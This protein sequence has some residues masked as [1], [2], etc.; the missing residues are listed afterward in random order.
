MKSK[1]FT[2]VFFMIIFSGFGASATIEMNKGWN[3]ISSHANGLGVSEIE[4]ECDREGGP[5][6]W[7][8]EQGEF[9]YLN[10]GE[11]QDMNPYKGYWVKVESDCE[12][13]FKGTPPEKDKLD[14]H[15]GWNLVSSAFENWGREEIDDYCARS[16]G[17]WYD[18]NSGWE[19][20]LENNLD[21]F[22]GYWVKVKSDCEINLPTSTQNREDGSDS[23][24]EDSSTSDSSSDSDSS[25]RFSW[26]VNG[27]KPDSVV[28]HGQEKKYSFM[29]KDEESELS[30]AEISLKG[31]PKETGDWAWNEFKSK[32]CESKTPSFCNVEAKVDIAGEGGEY[33]F[34]ANV[35]TE[36]GTSVSKN[37]VY[38]E[39]EDLVRGWEKVKKPIDGKQSVL[40]TFSSSGLP[41]EIDTGKFG[42]CGA[43]F[44]KKEMDED[45]EYTANFKIDL[46]MDQWSGRA[47]LSLAD[48]DDET[49]IHEV[50]PSGE[51]VE[52]T[53]DWRV[54]IQDGDVLKLGIDDDSNEH[55]NKDDHSIE[56]R[57]TD[58][59][60]E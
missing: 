60:V 4:D 12:I 34:K 48:A 53:E 51:K 14:L 17:P 23:D 33:I 30:G 31:K 7:S 9:V 42:Y 26:Q 24:K 43:A 40:K 18:S 1:I 8:V 57:I 2:I 55:C 3:L 35:N 13:S 19:S 20:E 45:R 41:K 16:G 56:M 49:V 6:Q 22:T 21:S 25:N 10:E 15:A 50:N 32:T 39:T 54:E 47:A 29:I 44:F 5:W 58:I 59:S 37:W 38:Y 36:D 52:K 11:P 28:M 27:V 46:E